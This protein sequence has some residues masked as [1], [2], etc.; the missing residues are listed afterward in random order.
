MRKRI[1]LSKGYYATVDSD[2]YEY[3]NQWKWYYR[4]GY[5]VRHSEENHKNEIQMHRVVMG[6]PYKTNGLDV[7]HKDGKN[8]PKDMRGLNNQSNNL[9]WATRAQ[10]SY[11]SRVS[12]N[13]TT[14][15]KGVHWNKRDKKYI[16]RVRCGGKIVY[17]GNFD[18]PEDAAK[19][20]N[21][22]AK[23]YFGEFVVLNLIGA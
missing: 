4:D 12:K 23:E 17:Q 8:L 14:G 11:N 18:T 22:A 15:Y 13:S 5:A 16:A 2:W 21:S 6:D 9:R 20:Y 19:A 1:P 3:L 7:D 10:N